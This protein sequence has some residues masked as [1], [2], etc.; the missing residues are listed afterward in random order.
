M[1]IINA[2]SPNGF[3]AK[4]NY[5]G[6]DAQAKRGILSLKYPIDRG[7]I[8]D[9]EDM[10]RLWEYSFGMNHTDPSNDDF[11]SNFSKYSRTPNIA[12]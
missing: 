9:F 2:H 7:L 10:E 8:T 5:V 11:S 4:E 6:N 1:N 12:D 3:V